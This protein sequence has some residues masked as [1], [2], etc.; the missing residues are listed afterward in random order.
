MPIENVASISKSHPL[1]LRVLRLIS[2][3]SS[4][5]GRIKHR[6]HKILHSTLRNEYLKKSKK[7]SKNCA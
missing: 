7:K 2:E 6:K 4:F 1:A 3:N 5:F